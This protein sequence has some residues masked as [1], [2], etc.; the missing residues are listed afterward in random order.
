MFEIMSKRCDEC[1]YGKN[2]VVSN[3]RRAEIIRGLNKR[4]DFFI[5]HKASLAGRKVA[6]H[7]DWEQRQCGQAGQVVSRLERI[8]QRVLI[9]FVDEADLKP[10]DSMD[11]KIT[12]FVRNGRVIKDP[13]G[14]LFTAKFPNGARYYYRTM[15]KANVGRMYAAALA[16]VPKLNKRSKSGWA[17]L[18]RAV[19]MEQPRLTKKGTRRSKGSMS[20]GVS[21]VIFSMATRYGTLPTDPEK[22]NKLLELAG[23]PWS[24]DP[25][26]RL[27]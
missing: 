20:A 6:C 11:L 15:Q 2:K 10:G 9:K 7:G 12:G 5:C 1:L 21:N 13:T 24:T 17:D 27:P 22:R 18:A 26:L 19:G 4:D 8:W 14:G 23:P 16:N 3:A 25:D